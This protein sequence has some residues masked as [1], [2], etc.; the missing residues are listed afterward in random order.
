MLIRCSTEWWLPHQ[1]VDAFHRN[2]STFY[3]FHRQTDYLQPLILIGR[4]ITNLKRAGVDFGGS[5]ESESSRLSSVRFAGLS[6][7]LGNIGQSL[8][9]SAATVVFE[10]MEEITA[11]SSLGQP[12]D[13]CDTV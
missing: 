2:I 10:D 1:S 12:D 11:S 5:T 9:R 6:N 7:R 13:D 3:R 8:D 4:F